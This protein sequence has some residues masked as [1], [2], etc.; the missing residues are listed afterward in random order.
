MKKLYILSASILLTTGLFAQRA[1]NGNVLSENYQIN[2]NSQRDVTDTLSGNF[3]SGCNVAPTLYGSD[4]G[5]YVTGGNGYGDKEIAQF[6]ETETQGSIYSTLVYIAAKEGGTNE[7]FHSKIYDGTLADGPS[8]SVVTSNAVNYADLDT[9]GNYTTFTFDS[10]QPYNGSFYISFEVSQSSALYGIVSTGDGC[11]GESS[12]SLSSDDEWASINSTWGVDLGL[13][14][15]AEVD[16]GT[17]GIDNINLIERGSQKV[18]PNP[19]NESANLIYSLTEATNITVRVYTTTGVLVD[20]YNPGIQ[21]TGLNQLTINT[22]N[23]SQGMY[24]YSIATEK[25]VRNG[26]FSVIR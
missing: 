26:N 11:A 5:G 24:I 13:Y 19:A 14:A 4:N 21:N 15:F 1:N 18:F 3:I 9:L 12:W 16:M 22:T 10:P 7:D 2:R 20:T 25:G 17:V 23:L 8:A 6:I